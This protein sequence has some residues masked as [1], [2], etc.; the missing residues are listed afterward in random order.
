MKTELLH[1]YSTVSLSGLSRSLSQLS[2]SQGGQAGNNN[3][4]PEVNGK[5]SVSQANLPD[6]KAQGPTF[7]EGL[8]EWGRNT[9][10]K[11]TLY[12]KVP[13]LNWIPEYSL[14][15]MMCDLIAGLTVGLTILPQALA[16]AS[17]AGLPP[18]VRS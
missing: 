12:R 15:K 10:R 9:F 11:K 8:Q 6:S 4:S 14:N 13:F 1:S 7:V 18:Q 3:L 16:Y 5:Y 17:L 2:L